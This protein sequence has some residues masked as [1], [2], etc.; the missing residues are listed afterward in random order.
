MGRV[1]QRSGGG[2]GRALARGLQTRVSRNS[3]AEVGRGPK[4][5]IYLFLPGWGGNQHDYDAKMR[6]TCGICQKS[7]PVLP[8]H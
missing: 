8:M 4:I 1:G 6:V 7:I 5:F 3:C 2:G